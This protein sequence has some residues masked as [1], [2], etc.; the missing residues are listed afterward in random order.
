[1][2]YG[3]K[4]WV[5]YF[6]AQQILRSQGPPSV[7]GTRRPV[8][9]FRRVLGPGVDRSNEMLGPNFPLLVPCPWSCP[10]R[11]LEPVYGRPCL[12]LWLVLWKVFLRLTTYRLLTCLYHLRLGTSQPTRRFNFKSTGSVIPVTRI[13]QGNAQAEEREAL[14]RADYKHG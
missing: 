4:L 13:S 10:H 2:F 8:S 11:F 7:S 14:S 1:M 12:P 9:T 6:H 5:V 3:W